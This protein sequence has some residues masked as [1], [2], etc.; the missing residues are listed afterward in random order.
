MAHMFSPSCPSYTDPCL[1][2]FFFSFTDQVLQKCADEAEEKS[3]N[4]DNAGRRRRSIVTQ[5]LA[6][7]GL[8][9]SLSS[10]HVRGSDVYSRLPYRQSS[11]G[12][13]YKTPGKLD[14]YPLN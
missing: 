2:S 6:G 4:D 9:S 11:Y 7:L 5:S 14:Q 10:Y 13:Y 1:F 8:L 3:D 12:Y